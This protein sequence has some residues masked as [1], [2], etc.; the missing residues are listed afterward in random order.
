M[1]AFTPMPADSAAE[2]I[3]APPAPARSRRRCTAGLS[4]A[5][6]AFALLLAVSAV[7]TRSASGGL[8]PLPLDVCE[9]DKDFDDYGM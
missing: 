7:V 5:S 2:K 4:G 3:P 6:R 9:I 1:P 8:P